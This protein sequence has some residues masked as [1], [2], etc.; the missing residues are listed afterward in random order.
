MDVITLVILT[1]RG[2]GSR[3]GFFVPQSPRRALYK[4]YE[5]SGL[6]LDN[7]LRVIAEFCKSLQALNF[8]F[9]SN[10]KPKILSFSLSLDLSFCAVLIHSVCTFSDY[11]THGP[12]HEFRGL[13]GERF[14]R[15]WY[16]IEEKSFCMDLNLDEESI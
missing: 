5:G 4:L 11:Q 16:H 1:L 9:L 2:D 13:L 14:G 15:S 3:L 6:K 10:I 8:S 12:H 7:S